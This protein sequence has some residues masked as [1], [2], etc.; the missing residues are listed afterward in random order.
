MCLQN[1][2][3]A[4]CSC[5][6]GC[7]RA[8][9]KSADGTKSESYIF[10]FNCVGAAVDDID[11]GYHNGGTGH[12]NVLSALFPSTRIDRLHTLCLSDCSFVCVCVCVLS[13]IHI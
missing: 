1:P 9:I 4:T 5:K 8:G 7:G 6:G 2:S 10:I 3:G 13:L 12:R 11:C